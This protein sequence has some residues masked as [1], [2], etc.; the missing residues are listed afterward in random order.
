MLKIHTMIEHLRKLTLLL[1]NFYGLRQI[2]IDI[3]R[4]PQEGGLRRIKL[5][6]LVLVLVQME[7]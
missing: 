4:F 1:K 3:T 2:P 5:I 7:L 6:V